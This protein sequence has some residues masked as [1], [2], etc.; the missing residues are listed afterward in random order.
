MLGGV[1]QCSSLSLLSHHH[2]QKKVSLE[3]LP[4]HVTWR[5]WAALVTRR[6]EKVS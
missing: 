2:L 6:T 1:T 5:A 4:P 3:A